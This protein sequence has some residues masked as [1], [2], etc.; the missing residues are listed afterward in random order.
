[1]SVVAEKKSY[2]VLHLVP[3]GGGGVGTVLRSLLDC[4]KKDFQVSLCSLEYLNEPMKQWAGEHNISYLEN[5]WQNKKELCLLLEKADIVHIHW[6][7]HPLLHAL[8][9]WCDLPPM[10]VVLWS[11]VNG[12]HAPQ[13]FF[14]ELLDFPDIFVLATPQSY[15]AK[16]VQN[17]MNQRKDAVYHIQ[18][19]AGIPLDAPT[20]LPQRKTCKT[21][22][23]GTVDYS[24]M[25]E[26]LIDLW[27]RTGIR[28]H[29]LIICGGPSHKELR[30]EIKQKG[31]QQFFDIRGSIDNVSEVLQE[32][33]IFFYP[34][35]SKHYGTGE[36]VLIEAMS[37]GVVPVVFAG[38]CEEFVVEHEKTGLVA[39]STHEFTSMVRYLHEHK[40][41]CQRL[42][43]N[44]LVESRKRFSLL[45]TVDQWRDIYQRLLSV[46]KTKKK[47][48]LRDD[49][50]FSQ[51][52]PMSL[53]LTSYGSSK[54]GQNLQQLLGDE[55][56]WKTA[57]MSAAMLSQTRGA[58][59]HYKSFFPDDRDLAACCR[60]MSESLIKG[61]KQ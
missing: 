21:G 14:P 60:K 19:N 15:Q 8:L 48:L 12:L 36:Q 32:L 58:P 28:D 55:S 16:T 57:G 10:R 5:G 24:K 27:L 37:F 23:I 35:Q 11:H 54:E 51:K 26:D 1:M 3:H 2:H 18:S 46:E 45:H 17:C 30:S 59:F 52:S 20:L 22:Y 33:S 4:Q 61:G 6:W 31:C 40:D 29:H 41:E 34:L 53:L 44:C 42:A 39:G 50:S 49:L 9:A 38:G 43:Q 56:R 47:L 13:I 7:N 25:H